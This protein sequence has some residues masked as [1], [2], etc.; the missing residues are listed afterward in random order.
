MTGIPVR[1][2]AQEESEKLLH[3]E[4]ELRSRVVGQDEALTIV[5]KAVRRNRAGLRDPRRPIG[6]FIFLG[7]TGVGKTELARTLA[8]FLFEDETALIRLDMSEYMGRFAVSRHVGAP[9]GYVG[10]EEGGQLTEKVRR[11][12]YS[13]VLLDE[14]EKAHPDVFNILLQV[15]EDGQLTDSFGRTVDFRNTVI[16]MTSNVGA[17]D[18]A[19][20]PGIGFQLGEEIDIYERMKG[21]AT[22]ALKRVFNPEFLNRVDGT[23]V[24]HALG[25][26]EMGQIVEILLREVEE[27]LKE[28]GIRLKISASARELLIEKGFDPAYG[29]RPLRRAIQRYLEDPLS[30]EVLKGRHSEGDLILVERKGEELAFKTSRKKMEAAA[31]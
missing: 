27:R 10:Y 11:R 5:S 21:Q 22:E 17:R 3:M 2:L 28:A 6:S 14:I 13:V 18:I 12:P 26:E 16:I 7:P 8:S 31:H 20:G 29:A 19:Q 4:D 30:E 1:R 25:I 15:L 9:P 23:V 24:F